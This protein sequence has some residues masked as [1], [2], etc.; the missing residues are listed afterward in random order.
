[1]K[2]GESD[3]IQKK[4]NNIPRNASAIIFSPYLIIEML[5]LSIQQ[6][7]LRFLTVIIQVSK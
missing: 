2:T 1:M 4:V 7:L 3:V 6:C 5:M